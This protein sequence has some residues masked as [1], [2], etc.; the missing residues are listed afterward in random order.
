MLTKCGTI[1]FKDTISKPRFL[2]LRFMGAYDL[3]SMNHLEINKKINCKTFLN[4][5]LIFKYTITNIQ[6]MPV[7]R[8][9]CNLFL[10]C[11]GFVNQ[12]IQPYSS[13]QLMELEAEFCL[14]PYLNA[15]R[16][17]QLAKTTSLSERQVLLL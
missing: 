9:V 3:L 17:I 14:H 6:H 10:H 15:D 8:P 16:R 5:Y 1:A 7:H 12:G 4:Q 2:R 11:I 13:R